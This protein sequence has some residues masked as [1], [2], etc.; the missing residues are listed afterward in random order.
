MC[1]PAVQRRLFGR[2]DSV[3]VQDIPDTCLTTCR[4]DVSRHRRQPVEPRPC[5]SQ[6]RG[7]GPRRPV[8][9][10]PPS[11]S[12]TA[13][14]P[15]SSPT[16]AS[17]S[18][19]SMSCWPATA[20]RATPRSSHDRGDQRPHPAPP[21][22]R[23][24]TWSCDLRKDLTDRGLDAGPDT[25]GWH[26]THHHR[27]DGVASHHQPHPD[28]RRHRHP[29]PHEAT[30]VLL[31]PVRSRDAQRDLAVRLHP[32]PTHQTRRPPRRRHRDHQLARRPLPLRTPRHRP[33]PGHRHDRA[34]HLPTSR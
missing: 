33:P 3:L 15:M 13:P 10:S 1:V 29:G 20:P 24:S 2:A 18:P 27:H 8:W 25:I 7:Q 34:R 31:H 28:P 22:P 12:R 16:T 26:L 30:E 17:R 14:S 6:R 5:R 21:Q 9:S 32:L 23:S 19:G 11:P 4:T